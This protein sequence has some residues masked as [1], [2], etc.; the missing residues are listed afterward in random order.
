MDFSLN[1]EQEML[2]KMFSDFAAKEVAKV[3]DQ[4]DKQEALPR[5][6]LKRRPRRDSSARS[7]RRSRMAAR[8]S[9]Q[10]ASPCCW[11]HWPPS[12]PARP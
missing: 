5:K 10:S 1:S 7:R 11:R 3:A 4:A 2:R 8:A 12:A 6:L 9:M